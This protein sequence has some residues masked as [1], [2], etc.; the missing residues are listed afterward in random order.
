MHRFIPAMLVAYRPA[1]R[2]A[3]GKPLR[4]ILCQ[5]RGEGRAGSVRL[6]HV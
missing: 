1:D 3:I 2:K 5:G 4:E 6:I